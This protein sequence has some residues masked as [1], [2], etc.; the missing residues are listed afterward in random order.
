MLLLASLGGACE[1][2]GDDEDIEGD[3][4]FDED[5]PVEFGE[6]ALSLGV[7][8]VQTL[9]VRACCSFDTLI[10][11]PQLCPDGPISAEA[12]APSQFFTL[13]L[14]TSIVGASAGGLVEL[15]VR[16]DP[17]AEATTSFSS[18]FV[19]APSDEP[20]AAFASFSTADTFPCDAPMEVS[21]LRTDE[22]DSTLDLEV[23]LLARG[24]HSTGFD[25]VELVE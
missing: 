3:D 22:V 24:F 9:G 20:V 4:G 14:S 7:G 1:T 16:V 15:V 5:G 19:E 25:Q 10:D 21:F 11:Q 2:G 6:A 13:E 8:E 17:P 23:V 12:F 18:G